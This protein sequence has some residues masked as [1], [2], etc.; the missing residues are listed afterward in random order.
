MATPTPPQSFLGVIGLSLPAHV[1][2]IL[3]G[4]VFGISGFVH[5]AILGDLEAASS[6]A[7]LV[8]GGV[9]VGA[10]EGPTTVVPLI[11]SKFLI[12][13]GILVGAGSKVL[14]LYFSNVYGSHPFVT[15]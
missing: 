5:K 8:L 6:V 3:N 11:S 13:S 15:L 7:G 9:A 10:F 12:L 2:L 14:F 1:L 4:S